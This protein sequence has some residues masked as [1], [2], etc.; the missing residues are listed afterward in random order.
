MNVTPKQL[1]N[2]GNKRYAE[3]PEEFEA[4][5]IDKEGNPIK[6]YGDSCVVYLTKLDT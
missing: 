3:N 4:S 5:T 2:E 6:D 1:F